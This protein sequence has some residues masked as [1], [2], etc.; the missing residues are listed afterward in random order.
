MIQHIISRVAVFTDAGY[1]YAA[2]EIALAPGVTPSR[3]NVEL[4]QPETIAKLRATAAAKAGGATLLRIYWYDGMLSTGISREQRILADSDDVKLRLG[5]IT[6]GRQKGVD[7]L[8]V[9]DLIELARNRAIS[10]AVL[11]SGDEDVRIGVQIAQSF[12]VRVHLVGIEPRQQNQ[13][14]SLSQEADTTTEWS[15]SDIS[16]ILTIINRPESGPGTSGLMRNTEIASTTA[17]VLEEA[18]EEFIT[19]IAPLNPSEIA[20][21][22]PNWIPA[23]FDRPLLA[24]SRNKIGRDLDSLEIDYIRSK[25]REKVGTRPY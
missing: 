17:S 10:D 15:K 9:T 7:S 23:Q 2:G 24:S 18:V 19:S 5:A 22:T 16:Q 4:N 13:S 6:R 21:I 12:G 25:F 20:E 3:A 11:L 1:L 14:D 8:I